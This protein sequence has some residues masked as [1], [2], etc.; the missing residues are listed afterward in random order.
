M[1]YRAPV[2]LDR[3]RN[4]AV[5]DVHVV[6]EHAGVSPKS[7][8]RVKRCGGLLLE[9]M[10]RMVWEMDER[11]VSAGWISLIHPP[12]TGVRGS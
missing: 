6:C 11:G 7:A 10:I 2:S 1:G 4:S 12:G 3:I 9:L 5:G 8:S